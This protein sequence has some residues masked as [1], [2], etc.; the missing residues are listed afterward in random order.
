MLRVY[1]VCLAIGGVILVPA[2]WLLFRLFKG[3]H[4]EAGR[5]AEDRA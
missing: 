2:L 5:R 3:G 4:P 1:L